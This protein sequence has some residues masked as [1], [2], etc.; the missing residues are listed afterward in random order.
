M[1]ACALIRL[2]LVLCEHLWRNVDKGG[3]T[4]LVEGGRAV[5]EVFKGKTFPLL[6]TESNGVLS[7]VKTPLV[8]LFFFFSFSVVAAETGHTYTSRDSTQTGCRS[9]ARRAMSS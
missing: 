2:R 6:E 4:H 9:S 5:L 1:G 7:F 8:L 3:D